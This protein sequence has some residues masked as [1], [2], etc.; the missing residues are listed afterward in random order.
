MW[1]CTD[2]TPLCARVVS[3]DEV[4]AEQPGTH[5][6][7]VAGGIGR[8]VARRI[9]RRVARLRVAVLGEPEPATTGK[10]EQGGAH[11]QIVSVRR[12]AAS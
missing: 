11:V 10:Q 12:V 4:V 3:R 5:R 6:G 8:G 9:V 2:C 1:E 7:R